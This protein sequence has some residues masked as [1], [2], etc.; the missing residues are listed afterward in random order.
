MRLGFV[1]AGGRSLRMGTDKALIL[2]DG[3]PLGRRLARMLAEVGC[4][5][6]W[7]VG[8]Q[9]ELRALGLPVVAEP[10]APED[11][12][13]PLWGVAAALRAAAAR[14]PE[15]L[16]L[17]CPCDLTGLRPEHLRLLLARGGPC[18]ARAGGRIHP[19]LA[20]LPAALAERAE[21]LAAEGAAAHAL[22][23]GLDPVDLPEEALHDSNRPEDLPPGA[24]V[25]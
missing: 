15:G 12:R 17:I 2:L 14:D 1:L 9:P 11:D 10:G 4:D 16:A 25:R 5:P 24:R 13:H 20:L 6:V 19:L 3:E 23:A 21:T 22:S 7:L 8:R 18:V